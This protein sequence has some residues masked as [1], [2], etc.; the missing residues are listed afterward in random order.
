[1]R[2]IKVFG[3]VV[4]V[5][6]MIGSMNTSARAQSLT[7][8]ALIN[9]DGKKIPAICL[10]AHVPPKDLCGPILQSVSAAQLQSARE[11][12]ERKIE[13]DSRALFQQNK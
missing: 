6:L 1:M 11:A 7:I 9:V 12:L 13:Q 4:G 3:P 10:I 8:D 2:G 5:G